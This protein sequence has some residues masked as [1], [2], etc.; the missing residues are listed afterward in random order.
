MVNAGAAQ[1]AGG[2]VPVGDA[3]LAPSAVAVGVDRCLRHAE[4]ARDLLRTQV[5]VDEA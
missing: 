3:Q 5:L 2:F 1:Q 4:F